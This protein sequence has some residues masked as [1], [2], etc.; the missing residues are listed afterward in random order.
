MDFWL[1]R[2][3]KFSTCARIKSDFSRWRRPPIG[4]LSAAAWRHSLTQRKPYA[5]SRNH[6]QTQNKTTAI[7]PSQYANVL[8][9][10]TED[11]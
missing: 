9:I 1:R 7:K 4:D 3:S 11:E 2:S 5:N 6:L 8:N 10:A